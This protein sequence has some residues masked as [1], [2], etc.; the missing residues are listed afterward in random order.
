MK[1]YRLRGYIS[2]DVNKNNVTILVDDIAYPF[3]TDIKKN[4]LGYYYR[5]KRIQ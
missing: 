2:V 4:V 5:R 3:E 1:E